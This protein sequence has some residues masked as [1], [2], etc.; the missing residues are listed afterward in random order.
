MWTNKN[1]PG[2]FTGHYVRDQDGE[3]VF[4]LKRDV[5]KGGKPRRITFESPSAAKKLGWVRG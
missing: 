5:S 1:V 2:V 3:R 4:Q